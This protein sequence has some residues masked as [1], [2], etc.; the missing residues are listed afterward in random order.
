MWL[1]ILLQNY[2]FLFF[3]TEKLN[4]A[5][6]K[7]RLAKDKHG[8]VV[9][10][11]AVCCKIAMTIILHLSIG[12][13]VYLVE[14]LCVQSA[15]ELNTWH[16]IIVPCVSCFSQLRG[17]ILEKLINEV[18]FCSKLGKI[19]NKPRS[20]FKSP[21]QVISFPLL[22]AW[23]QNKWAPWEP[24]RQELLLYSPNASW[25]TL[26]LMKLFFHVLFC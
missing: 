10:I 17:N 25:L 16:N 26:G 2:S 9:Y 23:I 3:F 22:K 7:C 15:E 5:S 1:L 21:L 8:H 4:T 18:N 6:G 11:S 19:W 14:N 13:L 12:W 24:N 20:I